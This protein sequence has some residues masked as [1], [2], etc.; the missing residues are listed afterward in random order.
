MSSGR[1]RTFSPINPATLPDLAVE[2]ARRQT[3]AALRSAADRASYAAF[4]TT[5]NQLAGKNYALIYRG[6]NAHQEVSDALSFVRADVGDA[7]PTETDPQRVDLSV[8]R[9]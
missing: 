1:F 7:S 4:L 9:L 2:L 6:R 3:P 5:R 8:G